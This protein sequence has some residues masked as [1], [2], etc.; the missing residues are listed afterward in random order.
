MGPGLVNITFL[1]AGMLFILS[2]G[3]LARQE[4][5]RRGNIFGIV[6][7]VLA[8]AAATLSEKFDNHLLLFAMMAPAAAL[9]LVVAARVKMEAMPQLVAI[10]HSFVGL[11]AVLVGISGFIA[12]THFHEVEGAIHLIEIYAGVFIGAITL[13]GSI[14]A[15]AKLQGLIGG[16]PLLLPARHFINLA[17]VLASIGLGVYFV[18]AQHDGGL[19][20]LLIM[21]GIALILGAHSVMAIGGA[22]M[23]VVVS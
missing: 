6:G 17:L 4:S 8:L 15:F 7:M 3:G 12:T 9:G 14:I 2:L 5:A 22:D 19:V 1:A 23:P 21:T 13:T 20:P 16:K 11:A 10:L 18:Q